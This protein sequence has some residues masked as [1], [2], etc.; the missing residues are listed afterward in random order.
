[1][2]G[3]LHRNDAPTFLLWGVSRRP[4][5]E[6]IAPFR[7]QPVG[8][9]RKTFFS[10]SIY[11]LISDTDW[12]VSATCFLRRSMSRAPAFFQVSVLKNLLLRFEGEKSRK[13]L[14]RFL[15]GMHNHL[16]LSELGRKG[17]EFLA[18]SVI[19]RPFLLRHSPRRSPR[20]HRGGDKGQERLPRH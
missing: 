6:L 7:G 18:H 13:L 1:M 4:K 5:P 11:F 20:L 17:G 10:S 8:V 12:I 2:S 15:E 14:V 9:A 3:C 19:F 16:H